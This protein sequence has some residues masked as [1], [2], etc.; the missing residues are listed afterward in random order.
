MLVLTFV[1]AMSDG[2]SAVRSFELPAG[3]LVGFKAAPGTSCDRLFEHA[4]S[5]HSASDPGESP[6][7]DWS[8][9]YV[10]LNIEQVLYVCVRT[11]TCVR[12]CIYTFMQTFALVHA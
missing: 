3:T 4:L 2:A 6:E 1:V 12:A 7:P 9:I 11:H 10:Q 8:G 5:C